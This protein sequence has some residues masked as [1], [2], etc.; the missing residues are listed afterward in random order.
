VTTLPTSTPILALG[1]DLKNAITLVVSGQA[2]VSQHIGDL[3]DHD[4]LRAFDETIRDFTA[5]YDLAPRDLTIVHDAHPQYAS[6]A[7]ALALDGA[8]TIGVQHH[9]AHVASVLAEHDALDRP[10]LGVAFDGT[11]YGDDG[12]IWGGEFFVGSVRDGFA[13][14][15]HLRAAALPGGDAAARHPVQAAAGFLA[16]IDGLPDLTA[17][18]F[19]FPVRYEQARAVMRGGLRVFPTTSAGR[20]FD[21]VAALAGFTRPITFE[22]QAAMWLE[23]RARDAHESPDVFDAP[24]IDDEI[25]WRG[26]LTAI[27]GARAAGVSPAI[28]ARAFHRGLAR[29]MA[30]A[31]GELAER[32]G[33][34]TVVLSGGVMQN[35]LLLEDLQTEMRSRALQIWINHDVPSNDGG[36]SL[37]QAALAAVA[38]PASHAV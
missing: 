29:A 6:T 33:V 14:V 21:A 32:A 28:L 36:L 4:S 12:A 20:L 10:V 8:R 15:A 16:Q 18:P 31:I 37:G 25:D 27:V 13:R 22:G 11:G 34:H 30:A 35:G 19:C 3:S 5:M 17:P 7:R 23:H 9:R 1:G 38:M 26:L 2:Y 24:F